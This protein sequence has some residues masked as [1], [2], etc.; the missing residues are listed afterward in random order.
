MASVSARHRLEGIQSQAL[1]KCNLARMIMQEVAGNNILNQT[2]YQR[3]LSYTRADL[4][5]V[6]AFLVGRRGGQSHQA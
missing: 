3:V 6:F 5:V 1:L 2:R 4:K